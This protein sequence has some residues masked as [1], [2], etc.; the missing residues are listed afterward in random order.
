MP[1]WFNTEV[2]PRSEMIEPPKGRLATVFKITWEEIWS[3][4]KEQNWSEY[5]GKVSSSLFNG[6]VRRLTSP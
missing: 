5:Y 4:Y 3:K 1:A 2:I 6:G